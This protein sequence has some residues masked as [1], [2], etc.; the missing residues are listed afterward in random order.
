MRTLSSVTIPVNSCSGTSSIFRTLSNKNKVFG[1]IVNGSNLFT[2]FAKGYIL[3]GWQ[4]SEYILEYY[5]LAV[6]ETNL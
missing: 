3:D 6:R 2:I 1:K 5:G 4:G